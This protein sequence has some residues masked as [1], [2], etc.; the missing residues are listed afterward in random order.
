[1]IE[2]IVLVLDTHHKS[3]YFCFTTIPVRFWH[4]ILES[5]SMP[6]HELHAGTAVRRMA[7]V[8]MDPQKRRSRIVLRCSEWSKSRRIA[9]LHVNGE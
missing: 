4:L 8:S 1:M 7:T 6:G 9:Q 5:D 3:I 2:I